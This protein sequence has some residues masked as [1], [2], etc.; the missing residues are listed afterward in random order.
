M[1]RRSTHPVQ[2]PIAVAPRSRRTLDQLTNRSD[3]LIHGCHPTPHHAG[4]MTR[5]RSDGKAVADRVTRLHLHVQASQYPD[6]HGKHVKRTNSL[7][8]ST[9]PGTA[10]KGADYLP[11]EVAYPLR[12]RRQPGSGSAMVNTVATCGWIR[13]GGPLCLVNIQTGIDSCRRAHACQER[14]A[15]AVDRPVRRTAAAERRKIR[16]CRPGD[17]PAGCNP[18]R[19][20]TAPQQEAQLTPPFGVGLVHGVQGAQAGEGRSMRWLKSRRDLDPI[21]L[22]TLAAACHLGDD[23]RV[24]VFLDHCS[25]V[26]ADRR[27]RCRVRRH[28]LR[29]IG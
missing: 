27:N 8:A 19:R 22:G 14:S 21:D 2:Q 28:R 1:R 25:P 20:G 15:T 4:T 3:A 5:R 26:L 10:I 24:A 9:P 18:G 7:F 6:S 13:N 17:S 12:R 29:H 11:R 23:H 16:W